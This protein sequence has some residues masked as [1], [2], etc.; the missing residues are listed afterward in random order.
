MSRILGYTKA[1]YPAAVQI[2]NSNTYQSTSANTLS[3]NLGPSIN[4]IDSIVLRSNFCQNDYSSPTDI[5]AVV[6]ITSQ[7]NAIT[8]YTVPFP[9]WQSCPN[10]KRTSLLVFLNDNDLSSL[11]QSDSAMTMTLITRDNLKM[12]QYNKK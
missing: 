3:S 6:P 5:L 4:L 10:T 2:L 8:Q 11:Y 7:Y 9:S 1:T 12:A